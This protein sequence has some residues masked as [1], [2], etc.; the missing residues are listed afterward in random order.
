FDTAQ[1]KFVLVPIDLGAATDQLFLILY[2]TG[3]RG[4]AS[5]TGAAATMGGAN[6]E[7]LYV[8][9]QGGF[10]GLDQANLRIPRSLLG[11]GEVNVALSVDGIAAN[12]VTVSVK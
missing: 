2:G 7:V 9:T 5:L 1:N 12:V 11:R 10:V 3:L 6:A 8:G 4:R